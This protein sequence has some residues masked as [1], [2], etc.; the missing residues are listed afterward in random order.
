MNSKQFINEIEI[1][2]TSL[3]PEIIPGLLKKQQ[4]ALGIDSDEISPEKAKQFVENVSEALAL[5]LGP[6]GS[7]SA[8]KLMMRKLRQSCSPEELEQMMVK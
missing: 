2:L 4:E 3:A 1:R 8:K 7:K 6:D 5:F